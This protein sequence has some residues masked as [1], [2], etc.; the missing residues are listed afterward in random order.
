MNNKTY[1]FLIL[2]TAILLFLSSCKKEKTYLYE[3]TETTVD[4]E[5]GIKGNVKSTLEFISIAYSDLF[6]SS[7]SNAELQNLTVAYNSF[8]DKKLI[9]DMIIRNFMNETGVNIPD[10]A[11][12]QADEGKFVTE[13]YK[14]LYNR[15][16]NEFE[17][18][19]MTNLIQSDTS[20][21]PE[22]VYYSFMTS[23]EYRYY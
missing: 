10:K 13:T 11:S 18:W 5:E 16:P 2:S 3:V 22:V 19:F 12:M 21:T 20:I 4:Q 6:G 9:E 1:S 7:I 8:G 17:K 15:E 14:L 23:N